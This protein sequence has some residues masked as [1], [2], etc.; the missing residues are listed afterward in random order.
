[1]SDR[2]LANPTYRDKAQRGARP[3]KDGGGVSRTHPGAAA[4]MLLGQGH[5]PVENETPRRKGLGLGLAMGWGTG[6][7]LEIAD[8]LHTV[9]HTKEWERRQW[10]P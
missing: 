2:H 5:R 7:E 1:M 9:P 8:A 10:P 3:A 4:T 6:H